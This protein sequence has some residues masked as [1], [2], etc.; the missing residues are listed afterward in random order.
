MNT[1]GSLEVI[2]GCMFSGK[3]EEL[4]RRLRRAQIARQKIAVFK[5]AIDNRYDDRN[6][7]SHAGIQF[8]AVAVGRAGDALF[9]A[10]QDGAAVVAF[11]EAQFFDEGIASVVQGLVV[12]HEM[13]VIVAGLDRDFRGEPFGQMPTLL[14]LADEVT[15]LSAIC[16][17]C[18]GKATMTQRLIDGE[19][20]PYHNPIVKVGGAEDYEARCRRHH[21]VPGRPRR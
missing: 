10:D 12:D 2:V 9:L 6:V 13:R 11:D 8:E 14:A 3:T 4:I 18:Q 20:A 21:F 5:P 1:G 7:V 15:T 17:V 16:G 19:P